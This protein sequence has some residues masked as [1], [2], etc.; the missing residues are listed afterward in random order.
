MQ[1]NN[2]KFEDI[3]HPLILEHS[4]PKFADGHLRNAV[5]D[6]FIA[7]FDLIRNRTGLDLDGA[8]LVERAFS[9]SDPRLILSELDTES[10]KNDQK[11]FIQIFKGAY[12]GIRNPKAHSL[13]SD[14]NII[15]TA[16]YLTFASLLARRVESSKLGNFIRYDGLYVSNDFFYLR[17]YKDDTVI[18][19]ASTKGSI[20]TIMSWLTKENISTK[21]LLS[22]TYTQN[23]HQ[24]D[25]TLSFS[26]GS[27]DYKGEVQGEHL[28]FQTYSHINTKKRIENYIFQQV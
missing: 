26:G 11:G 14:L 25:F 27:F 15:A 8:D 18:G 21:N 3:L 9:L 22:G 2:L 13:E 4:Y 19:V 20:S 1:K 7:V 16:Q 6:A 28:Q 24:I 10:G 5:L 12:L 23:N 17:F